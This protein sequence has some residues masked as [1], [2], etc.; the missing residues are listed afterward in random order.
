MKTFLSVEMK[1]KMKLQ[2]NVVL[3]A[4]IE[5]YKL[6]GSIGT[7]RGIIRQNPETGSCT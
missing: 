7:E 3:I 1:V 2:E 5:T 4:R 6:Q